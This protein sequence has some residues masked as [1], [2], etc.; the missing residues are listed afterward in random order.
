MAVVEKFVFETLCGQDE[1]AAIAP[2]WN[3]LL[4]NSICNRGF[5]SPAW[6]LAACKAHPELSPSV[7]IVRE[8]GK[9]MA[10]L[11]LAIRNT[12]NAAI[13]PNAMSNYNDMIAGQPEGPELASLLN[14]A[15]S[16]GR[17]YSRLDLGWIRQS[18]NLLR[19]VRMLEGVPCLRDCFQL[20][21]DY[22]FIDLP[23]SYEHYINS[24]TYMFRKGLGRSS[25]KAANDG[26]LVRELTQTDLKPQELPEVFL[27]LHLARFGEES[28]FHKQP[29][30][31]TMIRMALPE[32]FTERHIRVFGLLREDELLAIDICMVGADSLCTWN[33]GYAAESERWSPGRL[34]AS[35]GIRAAY[36]SGCAEYDLLRGM[37]PWKAA[38]ANRIRKVGHISIDLNRPR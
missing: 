13:F 15:I 19:A 27:R 22:S 3:A 18:S 30:N 35:A 12:D 28:A 24:R 21:R 4:R 36:A 2:E 23:E 25:R 20:E 5:S 8:N 11:P 37:Q 1:V 32:M 31:E 29:W 16:P 14:Y 34:L 10:V 7:A 9:L 6:F 38:W 33:G 26:L 17:L